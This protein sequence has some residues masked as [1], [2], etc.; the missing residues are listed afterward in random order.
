MVWDAVALLLRA[1]AMEQLSSIQGTAQLTK[2]F[3]ASRN[4][5]SIEEAWISRE[6]LRG[7]E[8]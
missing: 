3:P 1:Q 6:G 2:I 7:A 5:L 8:Y 4:V